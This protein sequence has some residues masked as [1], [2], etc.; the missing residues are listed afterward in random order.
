[1]STTQTRTINSENVTQRVLAGKWKS[2]S[3]WIA[4]NRW[5]TQYKWAAARLAQIL[6]NNFIRIQSLE[7]KRYYIRNRSTLSLTPDFVEQPGVDKELIENFRN[8]LA[9]EKFD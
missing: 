6:P 2:P 4:Q 5:P 3:D 1:V 7:S 8:E 9:T